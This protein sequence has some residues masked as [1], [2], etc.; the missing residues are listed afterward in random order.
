[1]IVMSK[2]FLTWDL[3]IVRR[4]VNGISGGVCRRWR[5][6]ANTGYLQVFGGKAATAT[7]VTL[8]SF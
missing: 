7:E 3:A 5:M 1:M 2:E 8:I 4:A 6:L